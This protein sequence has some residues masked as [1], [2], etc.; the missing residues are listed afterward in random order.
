MLVR[1]EIAFFIEADR[2]DIDRPG[3]FDVVGVLE[4][5][6][7][8]P[9]DRRGLDDLEITPVLEFVVRCRL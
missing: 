2:A 4:C 9:L 1:E 5:S 3:Q 6:S 8:T 7:D